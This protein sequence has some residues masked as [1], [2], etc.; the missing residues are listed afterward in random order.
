MLVTGATGFIGA[1]LTDQLIAR[2]DRVRALVRDDAAARLRWPRDVTLV[3]SLG[4]LPAEMRID[5]IVNLAGAPVAAGRWTA[6]RRRILMASRIDTTRA[7]G[8]L[9]AR[10]A[11]RPTVLINASAVGFYGDRGEERLGEDAPAGVGF[12]ADLVRCWEEEAARITG[13]RVC[14][15][16]LGMVFD[17][18]GGPLPLLALP[19]RFGVAAVLGDGR[20]WAPWIDLADAVRLI[21]T[22]LDDSRYAGPINAVA[23]DLITQSELTHA[24]AWHFHTPQWLRVPA[25]PL[26]LALGEMSDLFLA[27]QRV[28]P[29]R[30][31]ALGFRFLRPT[32]PDAFAGACAELPVRLRAAA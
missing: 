5:A 24:L 3:R 27:G 19:A 16:R 11:H 22:A 30:L 14:G 8:G 4:E 13:L 32:L 31:K 9:I 2:G 7:V 21:L 25:W 29:D 6:A 10:L 18:S 26:R 15:L 23:P 20:Q 12:M 17:W 28:E 1:V